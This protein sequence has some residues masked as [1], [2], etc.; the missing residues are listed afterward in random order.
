MTTNKNEIGFFNKD[1][2]RHS[3]DIEYKPTMPVKKTYIGTGEAPKAAP[4]GRQYPVKKTAK[5]IN[6][7][8]KTLRLPAQQYYELQAL[9]EISP[10]NRYVYELIAE[11]VDGAVR[12]MSQTSSDDFRAYQAALERI[13]MTDQRKRK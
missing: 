6:D 10:S 2:K 3:S 5:M 13:K 7:E 12:N 1:K 11:L 9:L 8:R 4:E